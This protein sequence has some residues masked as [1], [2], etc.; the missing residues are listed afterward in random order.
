MI[1]PPELEE[2]DLEQWPSVD[3]IS[4]PLLYYLVYRHFLL[5]L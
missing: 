1:L 4:D 5:R 3:L 2:R